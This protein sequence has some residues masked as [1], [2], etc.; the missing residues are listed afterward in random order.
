MFGVYVAAND[1][2]VGEFVDCREP[3]AATDIPPVIRANQ[4]TL[5]GAAVLDLSEPVEI[6]NPQIG[7]R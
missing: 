5:Y 6:T 1:I 3:I 4:N 2:D 7:G